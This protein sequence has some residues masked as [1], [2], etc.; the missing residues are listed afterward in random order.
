MNTVKNY[1]LYAL[2]SF[3]LIGMVFFGIKSYSHAIAYENI[4]TEIVALQGAEEQAKRQLEIFAMNL[5]GD[6]FG[7]ERQHNF[8]ALNTKKIHAMQEAQAY[9][10]YFMYLLGGVLLSFF[11][12]SLQAYTFFGAMSAMITLIF[13]LITP[14][15][16][17]TIHKEVDYLGDIVLSFESKGV[18]GSILKLFENGDIVVAL[19]IVLF[20]VFV[21]ILKVSTLL[22]VSIFMQSDFAHSLVKFFKFIGKWSM[23]DV[24]VVA[25]FL[26]YLTANKGDVS[27]AEIE[28]GL[29]FFLAYVLV[30]MLV[31]LSADKMLHQKKNN[32]G[33]AL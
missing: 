24:F 2:L 27:R 20:S 14:L 6:V 8:T 9:T 21:P 23:V 29:Y 3:L 12:L 15:L 28:V 4:T 26:V 33:L 18:L 10:R 1:I 13:G 30:S 32:L 31:S 7:T 22:F 25:V 5:V 11:F 17:V 16:M 19:V